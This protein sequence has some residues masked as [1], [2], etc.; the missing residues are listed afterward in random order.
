MYYNY[1]YLK[2][3]LL[4]NIAFIFHPV[5]LSSLPF[6][7]KKKTLYPHSPTVSRQISR[8]LYPPHLYTASTILIVFF[9]AKY[10]PDLL[11][12]Q[13]WTCCLSGFTLLVAL[14]M[15]MMM[16]GEEQASSLSLQN[17]VFVNGFEGS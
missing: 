15:M 17:V 7:N 8:N 3:C 1:Y 12:N 14:M 9:G 4:T 6:S 2:K 5:F 10:A 16:M 13:R 11:T